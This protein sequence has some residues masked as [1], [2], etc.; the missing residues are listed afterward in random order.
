MAKP[1]DDAKG[2]YADSQ[3]DPHATWRP[4]READCRNGFRRRDR[5]SDA[6]G[7]KEG[8]GFRSEL[9]PDEN[10]WQARGLKLSQESNRGVRHDRCKRVLEQQ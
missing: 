3:A 10:R 6:A 8:K 4:Q 2:Q 9:R 1:Q 5:Q 7:S